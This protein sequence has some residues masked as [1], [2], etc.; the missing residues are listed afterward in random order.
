MEPTK[1]NYNWLILADYL[2]TNMNKVKQSLGSDCT[3]LSFLTSREYNPKTEKYE[4]YTAYYAYMKNELGGRD[5]VT[6]KLSKSY[7][8]L[9]AKDFRELALYLGGR[10]YNGSTGAV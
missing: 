4:P 6:L 7:S 3:F 8:E 2:K 9:V 10:K 1:N 5:K